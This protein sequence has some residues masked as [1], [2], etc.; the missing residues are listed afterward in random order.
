MMDID[1]DEY[2]AYDNSDGDSYN[3][4]SIEAEIVHDSGKDLDSLVETVD[5]L[6][7]NEKEYILDKLVKREG[8]AMV[9][10]G[11][12]AGLVRYDSLG[13]MVSNLEKM[14]KKLP[15]YITAYLKNKPPLRKHRKNINYLR[16]AA[17][18]DTAVSADYLASLKR[19]D[20]ILGKKSLS[21]PVEERKNVYHKWNAAGLMA[22][23]A[24]IITLGVTVTPLILIGFAV[25]LVDVPILYEA[26]ST[27]NTNMTAFNRKIMGYASKKCNSLYYEISVVRES[28]TSLIEQLNNPVAIR[29]KYIS[30]MPELLSKVAT[31]KHELE[32]LVSAMKPLG[33]GSLPILQNQT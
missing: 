20:R 11:S 8:G 17:M 19:L 13:E 3:N 7:A 28:G 23:N 4:D 25:N 9:Y 5:N 1:I 15:D 29:S 24:A 22:Y 32:K 6:N 26:D 33:E 27:K 14:R 21:N 2:D 16:D 18:L 30:K 12:Q 10:V 31:T